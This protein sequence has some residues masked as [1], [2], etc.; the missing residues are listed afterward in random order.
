MP[1]LIVM[2]AEALPRPPEKLRAYAAA[3]RRARVRSLE[4]TEPRSSLRLSTASSEPV[5]VSVS[6]P[7]RRMGQL[8][9]S[10]AKIASPPQRRAR[11]AGGQLGD[12]AAGRDP[13]VTDGLAVREGK[14]TEPADVCGDG[15][16]ERRLVSSAQDGVGFAPWR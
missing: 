11:R 1:W 13:V 3:P 16:H 12:G 4:I 7:E 2:A 10:D 6:L 8:A 9:R 15:D 5:S 14:V